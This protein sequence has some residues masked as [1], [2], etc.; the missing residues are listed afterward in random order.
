M[1]EFETLLDFYEDKE[2][3]AKNFVKEQFK[4]K[5]S[6]REKQTYYGSSD[7][8]PEIVDKHSKEL[9]NDYINMINAYVKTIEA[10][11]E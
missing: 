2:T 6:D 3:F 5:K 11:L 9:I 7:F 1:N 10:L 4:T 8:R